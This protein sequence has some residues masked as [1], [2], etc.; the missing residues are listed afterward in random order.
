[1]AKRKTTEEQVETVEPIMMSDGPMVGLIVRY[2]ARYIDKIQPAL[3]V[4]VGE[5]NVCNLLVFADGPNDG[6]PASG[7]SY[8]MGGVQFDASGE[9]ENTWHFVE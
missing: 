1:M 4:A 2:V 3:V 8:W 6:F 7:S 9:Q 5:G